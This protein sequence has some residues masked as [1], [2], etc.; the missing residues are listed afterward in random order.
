MSEAANQEQ[1][2]NPA[3][4]PPVV[5]DPPKTDYV[6]RKD[7]ERAI[8]DM[9]KAKARARELEE[10]LKT[11]E[12]SKLKEKQEYKTLYERERDARIQSDEK[13]TK[14]EESY[15]NSQKYSALKTECL[16]LGILDTAVVDLDMYDLRNVQF[17][18]TSTGRVQ[19]INAKEVAEDLKRIKPHWFGAPGVARVNT[20]VPTTI[21]SGEVTYSDIMKLEAQYMKTRSPSDEAA[22]RKALLASK[23]VKS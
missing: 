6:L 10:K 12:E 15:I 1:V 5:E 16:K 21:G 18:T 19:V 8:D 2:V 22:Y 4:V 17:E 23:G 11:E 14:L 20:T 3:V 7:H 9:H 13:S